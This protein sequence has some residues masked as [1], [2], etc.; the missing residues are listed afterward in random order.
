MQAFL[1]TLKEF[2]YNIINLECLH[3]CIFHSRLR[4]IFVIYDGSWVA[5]KV[6]KISANI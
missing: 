6:K 4:S 3:Q 2:L 5:C 1:K